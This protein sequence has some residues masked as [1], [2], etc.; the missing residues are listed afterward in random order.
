MISGYG[1]EQSV[2][3]HLFERNLNRHRFPDTD[4]PDTVFPRRW[5]PRSPSGYGICRTA[6]NSGGAGPPGPIFSR[7]ML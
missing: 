6:Q 1:R 2:S 7:L 3:G 4:F 5:A